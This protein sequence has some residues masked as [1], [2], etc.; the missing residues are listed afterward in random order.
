M[1]DGIRSYLSH[2]SFEQKYLLVGALL[3]NLPDIDIFLGRFFGGHHTFHRT[4]THSLFGNLL[5]IPGTTFI[6][7]YLLQGSNSNYNSNNNRWKE[8]G[9]YLILVLSCVGSHLITDYITNYGT[10]LLYPFNKNLYSYGIATVFDFTFIVYFYVIFTLSYSNMFKQSHVMLFTAAT[11]TMLVLWKRAMLSE[12]FSKTYYAMVNER[13]KQIAINNTMITTTTST[14]STAQVP[15]NNN[16]KN[17]V[18]AW[19]QPSNCK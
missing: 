18:H 13:N 7:Q 9:K 14:T 12:A 4:F 6:V 19:L 10:A 11:F 5:I 1:F 3:G 8:Y 17:S 15:P 16:N 2:L